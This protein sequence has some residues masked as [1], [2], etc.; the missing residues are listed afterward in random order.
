MCV[1]GITFIVRILFCRCDQNYDCQDGS[2]EADC[3]IVEI[4][5]DRYL[6]D[7]PPPM[8]DYENLLTVIIDIEIT[9]ILL[10]DEVKDFCF[11]SINS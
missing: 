10:I 4:D 1:V 7:K 9:K 6:K 5:E 2:D 3:R 8:M 11:Q